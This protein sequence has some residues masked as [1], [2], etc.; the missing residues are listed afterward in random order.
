MVR[1]LVI[2]FFCL[3]ISFNV[4]GQRGVIDALN[5]QHGLVLENLSS[6]GFVQNSNYAI[7]NISSSNPA[8]LIN[9]DSTLVGISYQYVSMQNPGWLGDIMHKR[10]YP[11]LP[12]SIGAVY[13]LDNLRIGIGVSQRFNSLLDYGEIPITTVENPYGTGETFTAK[14]ET[15]VIGFSNL[16]SYSFP[17]LFHKNDLL[18]LGL[19]FTVD[20][21]DYLAKIWH[22]EGKGGGFKTSFSVGVHY[23]FEKRLH[24]GPFEIGFFYE[25]GSSFKEELKTNN[26]S[27]LVVV[28]VEP[29]TLQL[30]YPVIIP[31]VFDLIT[32]TP[33]KLNF[34]FIYS[35]ESMLHFS[36]NSRTVYWNK[37]NESWKN[38]SEFSCSFLFDYSSTTRFS[39]GLLSSD[40]Q[41]EDNDYNSQEINEKQ[42]VVYVTIG[43]HLDTNSFIYDFALADSHIYS[44]LWRRHTIF[45]SAVAIKL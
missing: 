9:F 39:F 33:D 40:P 16:Y 23:K 14:N 37:G 22:S 24:P 19:Q 3:V 6:F 18:S 5:F 34:G 21:M 15:L 8:S 17:S 25:K 4:L 41:V 36:L 28:D 20:R 31:R 38:C 2:S 10:A 26:V 35:P 32:H 42:K 11:L 29:D 1:I 7:E 12:Q 30:L 13:P 27:N 45:K 44:G 43:L